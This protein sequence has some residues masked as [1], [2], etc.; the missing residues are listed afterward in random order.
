MGKQL[1]SN[2]SRMLLYTALRSEP[3]Q[4]VHSYN[5]LRMVF[6]SVGIQPCADVPHQSTRNLDRFLDDYIVPLSL[7]DRADAGRFIEFVEHVVGLGADT[8]ACGEHAQRLLQSL[9][10]DGWKLIGGQ[11]VLVG[12]SVEDLFAQMSTGKPLEPIQR[13]WD[14]A[15]QSVESDPADA[16]TAANAMIEA[17]YK[18]VL[19]GL[20]LPLPEKQDVQHLASAVHK[21]LDLAPD[22]EVDPDMRRCLGGLLNVA[23]AIGAL[24]TKVGDAHGRGPSTQNPDPRH[25]RL[26]INA[27]GALCVFLLETYDA[28]SAADLQF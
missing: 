13:E 20:A 19:H 24:R 18:Y 6:Q 21:A 8:P 11:L 3:W 5:D 10:R 17:T 26:A 12:C 16:L 23:L 14:R 25:A 22:E 7:D 27:A 15:R 9:E 1:I 2:T 4:H 28:Q